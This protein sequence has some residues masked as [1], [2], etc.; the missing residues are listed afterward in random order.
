MTKAPDIRKK[1]ICFR[2]IKSKCMVEYDRVVFENVVEVCP[3]CKDTEFVEIKEEQ[4]VSKNTRISD[5]DNF[6]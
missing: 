2:C 4:T 6:Y 1:K 5:Y 3:K